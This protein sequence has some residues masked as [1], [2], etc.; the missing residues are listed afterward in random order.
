[1]HKNFPVLISFIRLLRSEKSQGKK[2]IF[3]GQGK[4]REF[5]FLTQC[6]KLGNR[7]LKLKLNLCERFQ[8]DRVFRF[9]NRTSIYFD[10]AKYLLNVQLIL[11]HVERRKIQISP[12]PGE[13]DRSNAPPQGQH[14]QSNPQPTPCPA[15]LFAI[16]FS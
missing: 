1:M 8:P 7:P 10:T 9:K 15:L 2:K 12:P 4:V 6:I 13:Q 14:R 3:R 5:C 16:Y 11:V